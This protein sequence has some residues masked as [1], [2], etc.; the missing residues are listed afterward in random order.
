MPEKFNLKKLANK[1]I[2]VV[3]CGWLGLPLAE[4]LID[5]GNDVHGTTRSIEKLKLLKSKGINAHQLIFDNSPIALQWL[6]KCDVIILN[7]PPSKLQTSY[8]KE[9]CK[10]VENTNALAKIIF[11]SSTSVYPNNNSIVDENTPIN[12]ETKNA[13]AIVTAEQKIKAIVGKRLTIIRFA[14]LV[15]GERH[16]V[17]YMSGKSYEN[18]GAPVNLIHL[19]DCIQLIESIIKEDFWGQVI[20]GCC[21]E[22]PSKKSYYTFAAKKLA[23]PPPIFKCQTKGTYKKVVSNILPTIKSFNYRYTS[24]YDFPLVKD[25]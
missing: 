8:A 4:K 18:G 20:N 21:S 5:K 13:Y 17:K 14:G 10:L 19:E 6:N 25:C 16:P 22:H 1:K 15:G 24:P 12:S 3:G 7:I 23:V 11:I 9:L 2:A